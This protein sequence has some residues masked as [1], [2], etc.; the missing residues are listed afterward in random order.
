MKLSQSNENQETSAKLQ[1]QTKLLENEIQT[2]KTSMN[3]TNK[4]KSKLTEES[5][6]MKAEN[7]K[8]LDQN[9]EL[10]ENIK[11]LTDENVS[12]TN[13]LET[14]DNKFGKI[15]EELTALT[16]EHDKANKEVTRKGTMIE[17]LNSK[18]EIL[19]ANTTTYEQ[20]V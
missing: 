12:Y 6:T 11:K 17:E 4:H 9:S 8:L 1:E 13:N 18:I 7:Q 15:T 14:L 10:Q 16:E 3:D 20:K 2:L 5:E 19:E